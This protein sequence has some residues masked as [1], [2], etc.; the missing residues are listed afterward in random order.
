VIWQLHCGPRAFVNQ[1]VVM[2]D[3]M[4][5]SWHG[6]TPRSRDVSPHWDRRKQ[7]DGFGFTADVGGMF[8]SDAASSQ[9]SRPHYGQPINSEVVQQQRQ[10]SMQSL[11]QSN[12]SQGSIPDRFRPP[13]AS[14]SS[15]SGVGNRASA[16]E[17]L[18]QVVEP[19]N[20]V[21]R[22]R[23]LVRVYDLG[24]T[25]VTRGVLN[26]VAKSYGAFHTG[27]EVYGREWSFGMT[28]DDVSTGVTWN[29]PGQNV[30]HTFRET[31][32]MGYTTLSPT[33]VLK[34]IDRLK[35]EWRGNTYQLL[36]RNC[37]HFSDEFCRH[38]GVARLPTWVNTLAETGAS[39]ADFID[40]A[41]SGY[42]GGEALFDFFRS[43]K[44]G[45]VGLVGGDQKVPEVIVY[46]G[47]ERRRYLEQEKGPYA[48]GYLNPP[49]PSPSELQRPPF[50]RPYQQL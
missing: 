48:A 25:Y 8:G 32:S 34:A 26:R 41:D 13:D 7:R 11:M 37:H 43:V 16:R 6:S 45:F 38:L 36:T 29:P 28:F 22:E 1:F 2:T 15:T 19:E 30:D 3:T 14:S 21:Y 4:F 49:P 50:S 35:I 27:V 31:L 20:R 33:E 47:V 44:N 40:S 17:A 18:P 10:S 9:A 46:D 42:D 5:S 24:T 12:A 39:T 23:V